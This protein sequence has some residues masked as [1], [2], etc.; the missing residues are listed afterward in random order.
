MSTMKAWAPRTVPPQLHLPLAV[1]T[2]PGS[3]VNKERHRNLLESRLEALVAKAG[4]AEREIALERLP[5]LQMAEPE[6]WPTLILMSDLMQG[7]LNQIDWPKEG[8]GMPLPAEQIREW[9]RDATLADVLNH[10]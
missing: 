10:L 1:L 6:S 9:V 3:E 5:D 4:P 2:T 8:M 7:A